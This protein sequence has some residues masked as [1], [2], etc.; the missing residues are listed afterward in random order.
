MSAI[1]PTLDEAATRYRSAAQTILA[2]FAKRRPAAIAQATPDSLNQAIEQFFT[3]STQLEH[4]SGNASP[5]Y[6][7]DVSQLGDY[8]I[9]LL[10]DLASWA[11]QLGLAEAKQ[12]V[13][14]T[15]LAIADW[16]VRHEGELRTLEPI[17]NAAAERANRTKDPRALEKLSDFIGGVLRATANVIKQDRET[18]NP[19]RP[20][21]VLHVNRGIVATRTHNAKVM[22][23]VF[24]ELVR[25][26][27]GDAPRFFAE[28]MQ[29]MDALNYPPHV[30]TVMA[31]YFDQWTRK[32]M[33]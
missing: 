7:D 30:R 20:W 15:T 25:A 10:A 17:V 12:D 11:A 24:D 32:T 28:G 18:N 19:G 3:I 29:Q 8:A 31:R 16:V 26:L 21:R 13:E 33:H 27:P 23:Q 2:V 14:A 4:E 9:T 6:K 22:E 5:V 1:I